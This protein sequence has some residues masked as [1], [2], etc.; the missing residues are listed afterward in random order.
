MN[1]SFTDIVNQL[2]YLKKDISELE[3]DCKTSKEEKKKKGI[4]LATNSENTNSDSSDE[5]MAAFTR[6]MKRL[7]NRGCPRNRKRPPMLYAMNAT[8]LN[9]YNLIV[10][11]L[12]RNVRRINK[13]NS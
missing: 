9:K 4:A 13:R 2:K 10:L 8:S 11:N 12:R 1:T 7:L 3:Q 6:K 5:E